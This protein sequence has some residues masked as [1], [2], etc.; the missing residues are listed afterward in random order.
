MK[1]DFIVELSGNN[2]SVTWKDRG[3]TELGSDNLL[4]DNELSYTTNF[5]ADDDNDAKKWTYKSGEHCMIAAMPSEG[6]DGYLAIA[7][8]NGAPYYVVITDKDTTDE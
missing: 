2:L 7:S 6:T 5:T 3:N 4:L 1:L 8:G